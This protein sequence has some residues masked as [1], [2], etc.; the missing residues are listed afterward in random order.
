MPPRGFRRMSWIEAN[1]LSFQSALISTLRSAD[2]GDN[3]Y[4]G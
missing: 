2:L 4:T 1:P 3:A